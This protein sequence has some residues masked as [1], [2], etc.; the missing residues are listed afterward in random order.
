MKR[1]L[2][3]SIVVS[4]MACASIAQAQHA[5]WPTDL[6]NWN[7]PALWVTVGNAGNALDSASHSENPSG[8]GAVSYVYN[9][10]KFEVTAGQYNAFLNA[11]AAL[12]DPHGLYNTY[13]WSNTYGC[14]I[15][16]TGSGTALNPY[17]YSVAD[18]YANRPVNYVSFWDA[19]R[20]AN[21]LNNGRGNSD[22]ETGAY[23]LGGYNGQDG[24]TIARNPGATFFLPSEDEWYKAAYHDKTAGLA[25]IYFDYPTSSNIVPINTL[26]NP[27]PGN[28]ANYY[29][30]YN[31]GNGTY[32]IG[33]PYYRTLAGDFENS[34]SP[35]G[36]F[37]QGGNLGEWN[38]TC[39]LSG[40]TWSTRGIRG[41]AE[42]SESHDLHAS[43]RGYSSPA[44]EYIYV[45]FRVAYVPEPSTLVLLGM[46]AIGLLA[47]AWQRRK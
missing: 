43:Y 16:Q 45:G 42:S 27:D 32:T 23:T 38:E 17:A 2:L 13:M 26:L 31:K 5:P 20:F 40:G 30:Y 35:Y 6:N 19:A 33:S 41:G 12:G 1:F 11:K 9:I 22:T 46:G 7:D 3:G 36:T 14:K 8:Q 10:G 34:A 47:Y 25:A 44:G 39:V 21:W 28:H 4:V 37:D 24:R 29:D 18:D 15:Q